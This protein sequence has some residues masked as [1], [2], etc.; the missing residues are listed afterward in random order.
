MKVLSFLGAVGLGIFSG[1]WIIASRRRR[2][3]MNRSFNGP[4]INIIQDRF[5]GRSVEAELVALGVLHHDARFLPVAGRQE[6]D[7]GR[8]DLEKPR[9]FVLKCGKSLRAHQPGADPDVQM[10]AVLDGLALGNPQEEQSR[11]DAR[12][13]DARERGPSSVRR[14]RAVEVAPRSEPSGRDGTS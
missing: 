2:T 11:T 6:T 7:T 3:D 1:A 5:A 13:I 4:T 14:Q 10:H 12:R 9:V 8:A